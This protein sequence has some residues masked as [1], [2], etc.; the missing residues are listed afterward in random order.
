M[1]RF[2]SGKVILDGDPAAGLVQYLIFE[3]ADGDVRQQ[4]AAFDVFDLRWK[5]LCLRH[6]ATALK[7]LHGERI[8][9]QDVKPSNV[10]L[11][12]GDSKLADLGRAACQDVSAPH[13]GFFVPGDPSY[14]PPELLY[15]FVSPEWTIRRLGCD[16]YLLGSMVVWFFT[17][18]GS[19]ALLVDRLHETHRPTSWRGTYSEVLPYLRDAFGQV[20]EN[21]RVDVPAGSA[22]DLSRIVQ[23][24][25]EPD[26]ALR[27][28]PKERTRPGNRFSLE[29]YISAFDLLAARAQYSTARN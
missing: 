10:L 17:G 29:R 28:H 27:G 2:S 22:A 12:K 3:K 21:F 24:L 7:Q 18:L 5:F 20:L 4:L 15:G 23:E 19:T 8:A 9:H 25:C 11:F 14:A 16:I 26:P 1:R 6:V 13:E